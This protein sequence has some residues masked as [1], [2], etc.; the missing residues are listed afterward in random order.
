MHKILNIDGYNCI[1]RYI[2]EKKRVKLKKFQL[3]EIHAGWV[4]RDILESNFKDDVLNV[5]LN[6]SLAGLGSRQILSIITQIFWSEPNDVILLEE[7]ELSLHPENQVL[8]HELF[9]EAISQ[10]KQII[11]SSH[12]PFFILALSRIIKKN[13]LN[14][15]DIAVHN[16]IS[17][18]GVHFFWLHFNPK[19]KC[20]LLVLCMCIT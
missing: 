11:C 20:I 7:P 18:T 9:A 3:P 2:W 6:S 13:S 15:E 19:S 4:R 14:L 10:G 1:N 5:S 16:Q 8:L 17:K 12:S